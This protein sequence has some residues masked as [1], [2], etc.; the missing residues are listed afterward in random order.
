MK[1]EK[2]LNM[3]GIRVLTCVKAGA[4]CD[5]R[6]LNECNQGFDNRSKD[7]MNLDQN[8]IEWYACADSC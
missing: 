3:G 7:K 2:H 6:K 5:K 1:T 8:W 4:L